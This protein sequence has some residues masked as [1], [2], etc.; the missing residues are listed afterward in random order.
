MI[1]EAIDRIRELV[2]AEQRI[3]SAPDNRV[4]GRYFLVAGD[5]IEGERFAVQEPKSVLHYSTA[6]VAR[7]VTADLEA[8]A[9]AEAFYSRERISVQVQRVHGAIDEHPEG[10]FALTWTH[11]LH[12]TSHPAFAAVRALEKTQVFTQ[13]ELI[14]FLRAKLNGHVSD[15]IVERFRA[16]KLTSDGSTDSVMAKGHE[17]VKRS[18][19][20]KVQEAGGRSIPDEITL[21]IPVH[22]LDETRDELHDV[23]VLVDAVPASDGSARFELTAVLNTLRAAERAALELIVTNLHAALP[24]SVPVYHAAV[25]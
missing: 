24:E 19:A 3:V 15:V 1:A 2:Q 4:T 8:G 21:T 18:L 17:S 12:L 13:R 25:R 11:S 10:G 14:H 5:S 16:L 7:A 9:T 22:D 20:Q 6:S 23:T